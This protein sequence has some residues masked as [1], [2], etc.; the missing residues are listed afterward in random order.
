MEILIASALVYWCIDEK[1]GF[2]LGIVL[3]ISLWLNLALKNLFVQIDFLDHGSFPSVYAQNSLVLLLLTASWFKKKW[4]FIPAAVL[5]LL[6]GFCLYFWDIILPANILAGWIVG[7][8]IFCVYFFAEKKTDTF[9]S[10][11]PPRIGMISASALA[12]AMILYRPSPFM[13]MP[14][15]ALFGIGFAYRLLKK[16]AKDSRNAGRLVFLFLR[17]AL[18]IFPL[19]LF[20][21]FYNDFLTLIGQT[22]NYELIIFISSVL[23]SLWVFAGIPLVLGKLQRSKTND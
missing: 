7:V 9:I 6:T 4:L 11:H 16:Y 18:G 13:L 22:G 21:F 12:F 2:H 10:S 3:L 8:I 1:K 14:A 5:I 20:Y 15:G 19:G 23:V 17:F